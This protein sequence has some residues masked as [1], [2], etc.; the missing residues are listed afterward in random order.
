[1]NRIRNNHK[2]YWLTQYIVLYGM[3]N[4]NLASHL[5][6][7]NG[8]NLSN[9]KT[10]GTWSTEHLTQLSSSPEA[11]LLGPA[12]IFMSGFDVFLCQHLLSYPGHHIC[13]LMFSDCSALHLA[14]KTL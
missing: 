11:S 6:K 2:T 7:K 13:W 10:D 8:Q 5:M 14:S 4:P 3:T 12:L 1:M 9:I